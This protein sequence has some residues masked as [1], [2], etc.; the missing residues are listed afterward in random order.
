V[1]PLLLPRRMEALALHP[2]AVARSEPGA[3]SDLQHRCARC[4]CYERC[5]RD[6]ACDPHNPAWK[7][8]CPNSP[9]LDALGECWWLRAFV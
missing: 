3:N 7:A 5:E 6:L 1:P 8:Y 9:L 4:E 2:A